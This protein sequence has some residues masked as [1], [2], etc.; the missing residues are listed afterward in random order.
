MI[1]RGEESMKRSVFLTLS[2]LVASAGMSVTA[3][4][5]APTCSD[6]VWGEIKCPA[7][8]NCL[9]IVERDG[10]WYAKMSAKVVRQ[11][12]TSTVVRFKNPDG[13]WGDSERT[14]PEE[15]MSAEIE[16]KTVEINDLIAGQEVNVYILST[17]NFELPDTE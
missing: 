8:Q 14:Y 1:T 3:M 13:S 7:V 2:A 10:A 17:D 6:A 12:A 16:G 15:G 9:E 5:Q 11:G 4:A